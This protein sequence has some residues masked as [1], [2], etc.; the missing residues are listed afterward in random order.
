MSS[1]PK[2]IAQPKFIAWNFPTGNKKL[3][4]VEKKQPINDA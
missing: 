4:L 1:K 2:F 3:L